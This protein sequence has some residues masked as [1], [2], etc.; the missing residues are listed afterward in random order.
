MLALQHEEVCLKAFL[1][2]G[3]RAT[4][5]LPQALLHKKA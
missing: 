5:S 2:I 4:F 1:Q 3:L